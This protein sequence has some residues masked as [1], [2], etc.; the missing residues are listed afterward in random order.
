MC[1]TKEKPFSC[2]VCSK[3]FSLK[4]GLQQHMRTHTQEKPF[5]CHWCGRAFSQIG[6]LKTHHH[7]H[8][9]EAPFKCNTCGAGF[10]NRGNMQKHQRVHTNPFLCKECGK[11]FKTIDRLRGHQMIHDNIKPFFCDSC[12]KAFISKS[13]LLTHSRVHT[14]EKPFTCD[15]CDKTFT[16]KSAVKQHRKLHTNEKPFLCDTCGKSFTQKVNLQHHLDTHAKEAHFDCETC[17]ERFQSQ[18]AL[19]S[20][21]QSHIT[22]VEPVDVCNICSESFYQTDEFEQHDG[23]PQFF[24][25]HL[26]SNVDKDEL[27]RLV[28]ETLLTPLPWITMKYSWPGHYLWLDL[29]KRVFNTVVSHSGY[30]QDLEIGH[31]NWLFFEKTV[32]K[33]SELTILLHKYVLQR[34]Q[35]VHLENILALKCWKCHPVSLVQG[36]SQC[37]KSINPNALDNKG[38]C[39]TFYCSVTM[40]RELGLIMMVSVHYCLLM[41]TL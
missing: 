12:P 15:L 28:Q 27:T 5:L 17:Q 19:N 26:M 38:S 31:P 2:E 23:S 32:S 16:Q 22:T 13:K 36:T 6:N 40:L 41:I 29:T 3:E 1:A 33:N 35:V 11:S 14:K 4:C 24:E 10:R 30:N 25:E 21:R 9:E 34:K 20:H 39:W 8:T 18:H 7:Q 37:L